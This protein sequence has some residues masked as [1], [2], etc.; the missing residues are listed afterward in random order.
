[1]AQIVICPYSMRSK[2]AKTLATALETTRVPDGAGLNSDTLI[3]NWGMGYSSGG[4]CKILNKR[5]NVALAC[6]KLTT[7]RILSEGGVSA[8]PEWTTDKQRAKEWLQSG[9]T[10]FC[11]T[12]LTGH[13]G[14]GIVVAKTVLDLVTAPLYTKFIDKDSEYRIHVFDGQ[15][16]DQ[17]KKVPATDGRAVTT[18]YIYSHSNGYVFKFADAPTVVKQAAITAVRALGLDFGAVDVMSKAE[19]GTAGIP[20]SYKAWVLEVNTAPGLVGTTIQA[21]TNAIKRKFGL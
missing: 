21:Y 5:E 4:R 12:K 17:R 11:R 19:R 18:D 16:I 2:S 9:S 13:S 20:M 8:T 1:M 7:L 10:V 15:V 3:V 6:N 14:Q